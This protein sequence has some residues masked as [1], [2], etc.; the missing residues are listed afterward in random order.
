MATDSLSLV[1]EFARAAQADDPFAFRF[2]PQDYLVRR[3]GGGVDSARLSWDAELLADLEAVRRPGRDPAIVQRL[4]ETLRRFLGSAGWSEREAELSAA[5]QAH[6]PVI[7]TI[8]SA[9]AELYALPWELLALRSTGQPDPPSGRHS[10]GG[11]LALSVVRWGRDRAHPDPISAASGRAGFAGN[12]ARRRAGAA[13][14][15]GH[16]A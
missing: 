9:A 5:V 12:R 3:A 1:L 16:A 15:G 4:G 7:L 6:R 13:G 14:P 8:R 10:R 2:A 11:R